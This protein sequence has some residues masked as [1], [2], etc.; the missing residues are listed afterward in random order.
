MGLE[1]STYS[2]GRPLPP[3]AVAAKGSGLA[4]YRNY[5]VFGMPWLIRRTAV[6]G[7]FAAGLGILSGMGNGISSGDWN[8]GAWI[9]VYSA[10]AFVTMVTIGPAL[11]TGVR[12]LEYSQP[13]ERALVAGAILLGLAI[14]FGVDSWASEHVMRIGK[15]EAPKGEP[16]TPEPIGAIFGALFLCLLYFLLGGGLAAKAYLTE[17]DRWNEARRARELS[18]LRLQKNEADLRLAVLQAQVEPH[19]L[20]NT[21]ASVRSLVRQEPARAEAMIEALTDY[22]RATIPHLRAQ[23]GAVDASLG[24]QL[25]IADS[26]LRLMQVRMG[27][28]LTYA[29]EADAG[30]R[31]LDFP[32]LTLISLVENAIKHGVEPKA[33]PGRVTVRAARVAT[34]RGARLEIAVEDD[35]AGLQA[36]MGTG[37][38]LANVREQLKARFGDAATFD[39]RNGASGGVVATIG[40]PA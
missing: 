15:F 5:P 36:G 38:G 3:E 32:P 8:A 22:L 9:M 4:S 1:S 33:G 34:D 30:L 17:I 11:A 16:A 21:L 19:F 14:S 12:Y 26:F 2:L 13:L 31:G 27:G 28:R 24:R 25:D 35:G 37:V 18:S 40:V 20:F 6:F 10:V 23:G 7:T 29:I 39:V